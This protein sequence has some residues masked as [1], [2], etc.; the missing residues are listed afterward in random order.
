[1]ADG[2]NYQGSHSRA[3]RSVINPP[4][5]NTQAQDI[6]IPQLLLMQLLIDFSKKEKISRCWCSHVTAGSFELSWQLCSPSSPVKSDCRPNHSV[7]K[8]S[9]Y[10]SKDTLIEF[11][12]SIFFL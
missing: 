11:C 10:T 3:S 7:A 8:A 6:V 5:L 1:M 4:P 9:G 12:P 2:A